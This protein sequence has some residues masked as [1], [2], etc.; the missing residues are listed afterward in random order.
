MKGIDHHERRRDIQQELCQL[1]LCVNIKKLFLRQQNAK[2]QNQKK[3]SHL[4]QNNGYLHI[5]SF[6][7]G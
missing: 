4:L 5:T 1:L 3:L 7:A 6:Q 2:A